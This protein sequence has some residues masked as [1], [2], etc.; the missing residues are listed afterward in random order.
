MAV[1][2]GFTREFTAAPTHG[3]FPGACD[4]AGYIDRSKQVRE[5]V[6]C[7]FDQHDFC[8]RRHRMGPLYVERCLL[9][10]A[11]VA[12]RLAAAGVDNLKD[13][14]CRGER[15]CRGFRRQTELSRENIEIVERGRVVES[16][17]DYD[18]VR[19]TRRRHVV[20]G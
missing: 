5:T 9:R 12:A 10:P 11:T 18:C 2:G 13:S 15:V 19:S 16:V 1:V 17:N 3:D 20:E 4:T 8:V 6:G 7:R 14:V